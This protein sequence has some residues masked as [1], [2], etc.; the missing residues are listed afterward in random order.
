MVTGVA[1]QLKQS[2]QLGSGHYQYLVFA[3]AG[4]GLIA[5]ILWIREMTAKYRIAHFSV[6][7]SGYLEGLEKVQQHRASG[8]DLALLDIPASAIDVAIDDA[9]AQNL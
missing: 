6:V 7:T 4:L 2:V 8:Y 1:E 9:E 5:F 3:A